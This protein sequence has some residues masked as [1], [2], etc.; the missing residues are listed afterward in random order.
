[1]E[2][3]IKGFHECYCCGYEF[4]WEAEINPVYF[5]AR[6]KAEVSV[7]FEAVGKEDNGNVKFEFVGICPK[8][9]VKNRFT[10]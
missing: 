9:G 10:K 8:C 3:Y 7:S 5:L 6:C 2:N 1:M 4:E